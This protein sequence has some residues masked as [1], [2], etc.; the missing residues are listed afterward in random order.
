MFP[1]L[2]EA[3][4][5]RRNARAFEDERFELEADA[6]ASLSYYQDRAATA[7]S[8]GQTGV[9]EVA[10]KR[11]LRKLAPGGAFP[12][13][14]MSANADDADDSTTL[15]Q[16]PPTKRARTNNTRPGLTEPTTQTANQHG[17]TAPAVLPASPCD[18]FPSRQ[19]NNT[20]TQ[21]SASLNKT[22]SLTIQVLPP[23]VLPERRGEDVSIHQ[24]ARGDKHLALA[25]ASNPHH[26]AKA[27][28]LID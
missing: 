11:L 12:R 19:T 17:S 28:Q 6:E 9:L 4:R 21:Q 18:I 22:A 10:S 23:Q 26:T 24:Y 15:P 3:G 27:L 2:A 13:I 1:Q 20:S 5:Y 16:P 8:P 7:S 14:N 25:V